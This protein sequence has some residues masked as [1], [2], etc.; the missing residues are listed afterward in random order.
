MSEGVSASE[1]TVALAKSVIRLPFIGE[2]C[3][4]RD[5]VR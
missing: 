3:R 5:V 2:E 1:A 4:L